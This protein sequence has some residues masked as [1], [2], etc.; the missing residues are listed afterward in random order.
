MLATRSMAKWEDVFREWSKP[1]GQSEQKRCENAVSVVQGA[2]R[3]RLGDAAIEVYAKGS[4]PN[5]V[6]VRADSDVDVSVRYTGGFY[7]ASEDGLSR[8]EIGLD[9]GSHG[10]DYNDL[11]RDVV[12]AASDRFGRDA[13]PKQIHIDVRENSYR[14]TADIVPCFKFRRYFRA[15][16]GAVRYHEGEALFRQGARVV[17]WPQQNYDNAVQKN[18][19]TG[20]RFKAIVRVLKHLR[21]EMEECGVREAAAVSSFDV[22]NLVWN[23]PDDHFGLP[24]CADEVRAGLA[25]LFNN[26]LD[27]ESC[28][29]WGEVNELKYFARGRREELHAWVSAAWNYVGFE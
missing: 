18:G 19:R 24:R 10:Y 27:D 1:P 7:W 17:N 6:N 22:L 9:G 5:R 28:R 15:S 29:D 11:W 21:N 25:F 16:S 26:T 14:V 2:V 20:R 3:A 13:V 23:V 8:A 12:A 4:Y